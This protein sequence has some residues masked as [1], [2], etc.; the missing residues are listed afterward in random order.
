MK[1]DEKRLG[2]FEL[3]LALTLLRLGDGAYGAAMLR[4]IEEHT[5]RRVSLGAVYKT[6]DRLER[7][8][9]VRSRVGEPTGVRGGRR[10]KFYRLETPG[11]RA[12]QR[13]L[14]DLRALSRGL[15]EQWRA[16]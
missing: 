13:T 8:G 2:D 7:K 10:R 6:L 1:R 16:V 3:V 9:M 4:E 15:D 14:G 11:K 12:L 5:A